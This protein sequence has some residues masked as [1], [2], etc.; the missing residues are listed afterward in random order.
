[1]EKWNDRHVIQERKVPADDENNLK[2]DKQH[3]GDMACVPGPER[4]PG[5][6]QFNEMIPGRAEFVEPM[7]REMQIPA[8][9]TRDGLRFVVMIKA[10]KIAPA[11]IAAQLD[12]PGADHDA[13]AKPAKKPDNQQRRPAFW[14]WA[15]ID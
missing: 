5:N 1:S 3:A 2:A 14:E 6:D 12:Q 8:N 7:R 15:T 4:K 10:G 11:R 9:R 13:K